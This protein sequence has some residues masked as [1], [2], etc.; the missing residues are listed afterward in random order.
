M[1]TNISKLTQKKSKQKYERCNQCNKMRKPL[2]E[3]HEICRFCYKSNTLFKPSGNK[4]VDD[5]IKNSQMEFVP[6]YQFKDIKFI[7][8]V[9]SYKATWINGR[10]LYWNKRMMNFRRRGPMQVVL[11]KINNSK[12]ITSKKLNEVQYCTY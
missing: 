10:I 8:K 4:F 11:K 2:D 7:N 6:Y 1:K 12:N 5:F 9:E 3:S